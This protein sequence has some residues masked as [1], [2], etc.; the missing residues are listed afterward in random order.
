[1]CVYIN[2]NR[3]TRDHF[4]PAEDEKGIS[5]KMGFCFTVHCKSQRYHNL[6][7]CSIGTRI[8]CDVTA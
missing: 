5:K 4:M 2:K 7:T 6:M 1:M 8:V 3:V